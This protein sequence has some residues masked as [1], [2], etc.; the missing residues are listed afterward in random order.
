MRKAVEAEVLS[1]PVPDGVRARIAALV[2]RYRENEDQYRSP[3]YNEAECC[4]DFIEPFFRALGWDVYNEEGAAEQYRE[5]VHEPSV[6]VGEETRAPDYSFRI[7]GNRRFFVEAKKPSVHIRDDVGPAYQLRRYAWSANLPLSILTDFDE[8]AVYDCRVRPRPGDAASVARIEFLT[9]R[10]YLDRLDYLYSTLSKTAVLRGSF[11]RYAED[12]RRHRGT[13]P[14][15]EAFLADIESWREALA[16]EIANHNKP[17]GLSV[18]DL[19]FAVQATIGRL[20]FFRIAEDRGVEEYGRLRTLGGGADVYRN[21]CRLYD[22]ADAKYNSGLFDFGPAGDALCPRLAVADKVLKP[23][24]KSLY[25]PE[26]PYEFSMIGADI[27][28]A[29]YERFLG[30]VIRLTASG[31]AKV[32][33]KPEVKKAGGVYYTPTYIVDYIVQHTVEEAANE[34]GTPERVAKLRVLDPACGS[35]SFLLGAYECLLRWHLRYYL[36]QGPAKLARGKN[37]VLVQAGE[38]DWRLSTSERKRILLNNLYGVDIDHQAVEVTKLNLLLKCMEGEVW[39]GLVRDRKLLHDRVLPNIDGN[40]KCGN[41]LIGTDYFHDRLVVDPEEERRVNPFDWDKEFPQIM[42]GG[43]FDCVIGNPPYIRIQ[44]LQTF[45]PGTPG[46]LGAHYR[47]AHKGNYDIYAAFLERGLALLRQRG[48]LGF[49]VAHRFFRTDYGSAL[50][51]LLSD[52][53]CVR[54][55][56]DFDG[57]MVFPNAS[58]NTTI[59]VLAK[60]P[61]DSFLYAQATFVQCAETEVRAAI[62]HGPS[63]PM[64]RIGHMPTTAFGSAPWVFVFEEERPLWRKLEAQALRLVDVTRRVYQ[65]LK[66]GA[67]PVFTGR[68]VG[69]HGGHLTLEMEVDGECH[70]LEVELVHPLIKGQEMGRYHIGVPVRRV[71]FPYLNG[72]LIPREAFERLYPLAWEY[73]L[74]NR[75][76]LE[77]RDHGKMH[78]PAWY[79]YSRTQ[80]L[81]VMW[82]PKIVTPDYYAHASFGYDADGSY[83]FYGGGAGGYGVLP[84]DAIDARYLLALLNSS[85]LDWYLHKISLRA[86]QTAFMYVKRY[87]ERLPIRPIDFSDP[88][89]VARHDKM[90]ALVERMLDLHKRL[91]EAKT[92]HERDVIERR[93]E[94]TDDEIDGLVY[95]LYGLTEEEI[96][97]V[98]GET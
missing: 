60:A 80:A 39:P 27:L 92:K 75:R 31:M 61:A 10:E 98:E 52:E 90:V 72:K 4:R 59:A 17:L 24:L 87:I 23:I 44:A 73:L 89:D 26:C 20:L 14:V 9:Y 51:G 41:S 12:K 45:S 19:N 66:T 76:G 64:F 34:A 81:D 28:G 21:L 82:R 32:E 16:K 96:A 85:L 3:A 93:I 78:G 29:V 35:G 1:L 68:E 47:S 18:Q 13:M 67:D 38:N 84:T 86:Y 30:K 53:K 2:E 22:E 43:G 77:S 54:A 57:F 70:D 8:L 91:P 62:E 6:K 79:G 50:R 83:Y 46:Y 15:D 48:L 42:K 33:E 63:P 65:G 97:I 74:A 88:K 25:Y 36:E 49:I 7:G 37:P 58:I 5:V 71:V 55:L 40:I 56:I 11:D 69:S 95:E 94:A